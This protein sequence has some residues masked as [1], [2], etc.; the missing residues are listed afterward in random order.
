MVM[1]CSG[2]IHLAAVSRV[3][4][5]ERDPDLCWQVNVTGTRVVFESARAARTQPW[6]LVASSREVYGETTV[7]PVTEDAPIR[8][9]NVYGQS[10]AAAER[11]QREAAADGLRTAIV[12]FSGV[13][14]SVQDHA[15]R[16]V[17]AFARAAAEGSTLLVNGRDRTFDFAHLD[18]V[19]QGVLQMVGM[20]DA[21]EDALPP[22]QLC[23]GEATSLQNLAEIANAAGGHLGRLA[24]RPG[25]RYEVTRFVGDPTRAL[26]VLGWQPA[27]GI[28]EGVARLVR[29]F[30]ALTVAG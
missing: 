27:V 6:V 17:P 30:A 4:W 25:R 5:G 7:L 28:R 12:R 20:L 26:R 8:P 21:G 3:V 15:D 16:V 24:F 9:V 1:N 14:G 29:A 11:I 2:I 10:K 23:T 18:D 19:T 13:Y 22:I